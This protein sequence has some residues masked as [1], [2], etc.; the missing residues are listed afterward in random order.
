MIF[1]LN[2]IDSM[3]LTCPPLTPV[4]LNLIKLIDSDFAA[5][6]TLL[7]YLMMVANEIADTIAN[8]CENIDEHFC[9]TVPT[10]ENVRKIYETGRHM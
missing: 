10:G 3:S 2:S 4:L 5:F 7:V 8:T 9:L 1:P 6:N